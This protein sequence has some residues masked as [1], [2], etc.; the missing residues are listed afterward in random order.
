MTRRRRYIRKIPRVASLIAREIALAKKTKAT[1][2]DIE[3]VQKAGFLTPEAKTQLL[4][5]ITAGTAPKRRA[6]M[7]G[8]YGLADMAGTVGSILGGPGAGTVAAGATRMLTKSIG[9]STKGG[10][11]G[12]SSDLWT[13]AGRGAYVGNG[14][15]NPQGSTRDMKVSG[16]ETNDLIFTHKEYLQDLTP[17]SGN[18]ETLYFQIINPGLSSSFPFLSQ[19]AQYYEEYEFIQCIYEVH[20]MI[21][22][23]NTTSQGNLIA[24]AQYNPV[25][26]PFTNKNSMENYEH[27]VSCKVTDS[28]FLG[29]EC[30]P[31]KRSG[32]VAEYI[33]TGPVPNGQDPKTY[34]MCN[35]QFCTYNA[36]PGLNIGELWV[37]YKVRLS[38]CKLPAIG[39]LPNLNI[40]MA[41][42]KQMAVTAST[43]NNF[44]RLGT[45]TVALPLLY[46]FQED[47]S[48]P[49][50]VVGAGY[51]MEFNG[52]VTKFYFP[53]QC[54]T[55]IFKVDFY[56]T[57]G[58]G[59]MQLISN[60]N[61]VY[62]SVVGGTPIGS[63]G[64]AGS[65]QGQF[66]FYIQVDAPGDEKCNFWWTGYPWGGGLTTA[67]IAITQVN[68]NFVNSTWE[69]GVP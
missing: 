31:D 12:H 32:N 63:V 28:M 1:E 24:V 9:R 20:S 27:A 43:Q 11:V 60:V 5:K 40:S 51:Q 66:S 6:L 38:K 56:Y 52:T 21:T 68:E 37:H 53:V 49:Q 7:R 10:V 47:N 58:A 26:A 4:G 64:P 55:G 36:Q 44:M 3:E 30:D 17:S 2:M 61:V 57:M 39:S 15:I 46:D 62:G 13:W 22:E 69:P 25:N 14:L 16:D 23:G 42:A 35:V 48:N 50:S 67:Y 19:I 8:A 45:S 18:F 29:I 65:T 33:R 54:T 59:N 41:W 34:D